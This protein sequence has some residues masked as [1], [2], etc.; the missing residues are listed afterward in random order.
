MKP[1]LWF[2]RG[3]DLIALKYV[4][5]L[6]FTHDAGDSHVSSA[7]LW[8]MVDQEKYVSLNLSL[9]SVAS[10]KSVTIQEVYVAT[11]QDVVKIGCEL[12]TNLNPKHVY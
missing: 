5:F 1:Y 11:N 9:V 8:E 3:I 12:L 10:L 4:S 6:L 7:P 2:F